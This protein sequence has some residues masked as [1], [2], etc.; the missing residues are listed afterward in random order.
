MDRSTPPRSFNLS[1]T[2]AF[3][4]G[5]PSQYFKDNFSLNRVD[6]RE[7]LHWIMKDSNRD[8]LE[9]KSL[10]REKEARRLKK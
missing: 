8:R 3:V 1:V 10:I 6:Y 9:V 2:Y 7:L 5:F 4:Q